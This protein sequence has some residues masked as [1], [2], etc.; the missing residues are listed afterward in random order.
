MNLS[1]QIVVFW[2]VMPYSDVY[3]QEYSVN[4]LLQPSLGI[5]SNME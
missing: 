4:F 2:V 3:V 1:I 5:K